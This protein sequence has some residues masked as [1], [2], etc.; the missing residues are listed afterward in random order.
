[1]FTINLYGQSEYHDNVINAVGA[2]LAPALP[3]GNR[4]G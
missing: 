1:M 3:N 2:G 4:K